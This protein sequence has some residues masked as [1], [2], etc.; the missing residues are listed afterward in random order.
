MAIKLE[1]GGR[2]A[3]MAWPLV[4]ELFFAASLKGYTCFSTLK[5][6]YKILNDIEDSENILCIDD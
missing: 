5:Y 1:G 6:K 4:K 2:K 3:F